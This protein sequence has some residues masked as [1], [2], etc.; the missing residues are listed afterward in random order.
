M[1]PDVAVPNAIAACAGDHSRPCRRGATPG[2]GR[3][4]GDRESRQ[5][6]ASSHPRFNLSSTFPPSASP[7]APA[8]AYSPAITFFGGVCT[9]GASSGALNDTTRRSFDT[10]R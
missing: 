7:A 1:E 4:V 2:K 5:R 10:P 6:K 8:P 3:T 9:T